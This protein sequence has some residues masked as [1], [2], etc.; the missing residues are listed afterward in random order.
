VQFTAETATGTLH[1]TYHGD[2][3]GSLVWLFATGRAFWLPNGEKP[4][5]KLLL[6]QGARPDRIAAQT[7]D[8]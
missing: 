6:L 4:L 8:P 7:T 1:A 5:A 2:F 3:T